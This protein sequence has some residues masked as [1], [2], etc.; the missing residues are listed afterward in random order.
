ML[1]RTV[2][3][4]WARPAA[5]ICAHCSGQD[6][7][8]ISY[9]HAGIAAAAAGVNSAASGSA[10]AINLRSTAFISGAAQAYRP[11]LT[12]ATLWWTTAYGGVCICVN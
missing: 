11:R 12:A 4:G 7:R 3:G 5:H 6:S 8:T 10:R 9:N 1:T 2:S